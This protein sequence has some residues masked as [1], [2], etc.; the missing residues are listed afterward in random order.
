MQYVNTRRTGGLLL[1]LGLFAG[2]TQTAL[3]V[4]T[5]SGEIISNTATVDYQV[6]T[7]P[8]RLRGMRRILRW[9]T[10]ST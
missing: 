6:G 8:R 5:Q 10:G 7:D 2:G 3:A 1:A 9:I 4:G